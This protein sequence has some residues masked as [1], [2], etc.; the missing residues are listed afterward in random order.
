MAKAK[1]SR[2]KDNQD[3]QDSQDNKKILHKSNNLPFQHYAS[4]L[5]ENKI[6]TN[7]MDKIR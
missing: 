4:L 3:N 6:L 1:E 2:V 7:K 5:K